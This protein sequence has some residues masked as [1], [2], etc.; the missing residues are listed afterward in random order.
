MTADLYLTREGLEKLKSELEVLL[1]SKRPEVAKRIKSARD[2]GDTSEN[3]EYIAAR[4]EQA[5]VEGRISELSDILKKAKVS[6]KVNNGSVFVGAT[7][8]VH[9]DGEN[10]TF[11]IVGAPE[12][13]PS[14]NK[15]SHESPLGSSLLGKKVGEKI[16]V[17]APIGKLTYTILKIE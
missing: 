17:D 4:E 13:D 8:T 7:V 1:E 15:I 2:M 3:A 10:E 5:F 6:V 9:V 12:A 16:S 11:Y 14:Q